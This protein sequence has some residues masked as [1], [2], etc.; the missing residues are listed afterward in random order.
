MTIFVVM[1]P[2][3]I[4]AVMEDMLRAGIN[5]ANEIID[6]INYKLAVR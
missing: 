1:V 3:F 6:R 2:A 5:K 4:M